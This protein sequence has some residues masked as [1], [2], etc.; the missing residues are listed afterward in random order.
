MSVAEGNIRA[1]C[2]NVVYFNTANEGQAAG[3]LVPKYAVRLQGCRGNRSGLL[4]LRRSLLG[5]PEGTDGTL[6]ASQGIVCYT[7]INAE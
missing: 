6:L 5:S 2:E 1:E 7:V 4:L 3:V